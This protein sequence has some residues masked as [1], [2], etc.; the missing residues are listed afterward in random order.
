MKR[1]RY[2]LTAMAYTFAIG[3]AFA[4][5]SIVTTEYFRS[6]KHVG[7]GP[8]I[9]VNPTPVP[10]GCSAYNSGTLCMIFVFGELEP[11]PCNIYR[12]TNCS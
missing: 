3:V 2:L 5:D 11:G 1:I 8:C 4:A 9:Q 7:R 6:V 10:F 12:D